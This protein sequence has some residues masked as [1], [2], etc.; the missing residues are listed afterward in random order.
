MNRSSTVRCQTFCPEFLSGK[1]V[2][3]Q[4]FWGVLVVRPKKRTESCFALHRRSGKALHWNYGIYCNLARGGAGVHAMRPKRRTR[5]ETRP[6]SFVRKRGP[7]NRPSR[8]PDRRGH[9]VRL[10]RRTRNGLHFF[11]HSYPKGLRPILSTIYSERLQ[12]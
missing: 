7:E 4:I 9:V 5:N 1:W 8:Q 10:K 3:G 12:V 11:G 6:R 2:T